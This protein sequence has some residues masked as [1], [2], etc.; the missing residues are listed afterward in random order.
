MPLE[1]GR[2]GAVER[3][4]T[5]LEIVFSDLGDE[6]CLLNIVANKTKKYVGIYSVLDVSTVVQLQHVPKPT[7]VSHG[8]VRP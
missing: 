1:R 3:A 7:S 4:R 8:S 5:S 6:P 2:H